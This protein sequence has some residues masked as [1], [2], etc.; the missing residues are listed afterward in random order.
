MRWIEPSN[1]NLFFVFFVHFC[2]NVHRSTHSRQPR[3]SIP[4]C[5]FAFSTEAGEKTTGSA[6]EHEATLVKSRLPIAIH[7]SARLTS[8][9][10]SA[11]LWQLI[12]GDVDSHDLTRLVRLFAE[13]HLRALTRLNLHLLPPTP[14]T[15]NRQKLGPFN[16]SSVAEFAPKWLVV[17]ANPCESEVPNFFFFFFC[18]AHFERLWSERRRLCASCLSQ[19]NTMYE[20]RHEK[21]F[22]HAIIPFWQR[23]NGQIAFI[24]RAFFLGCS[25]SK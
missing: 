2:F 14:I 3:K 1:V 13:R 7:F 18:L 6:G 21:S 22:P 20:H 11:Q 9:R 24:P 15:R 10:P 19:G 12:C 5:R 17:F 25:C 16:S 8:D 4:R 23:K